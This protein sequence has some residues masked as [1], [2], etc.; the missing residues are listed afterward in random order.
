[1]KKI[2]VLVVVLFISVFAFAQKVYFVYLQNE[3]HEP[4]F[5]RMNNKIYSSSSSGYLILSKLRDSSYNVNIGFPA[6][7]WPEQKFSFTVNKKD[8]GFLLK[9]FNEREWGLFDM[10]TMTVQM[11]AGNSEKDAIKTEKKEVNTFTEMLSKAADDSTLK[12][13]PVLVKTEEKKVEEIKQ[14]EEKKD[15]PKQE[16][17]KED[18]VIEK[19]EEIKPTEKKEEPVVEIKEQPVLN[20]VTKQIDSLELVTE[21]KPENK[22]AEGAYEKSTVKRRSESSTTEGFGLIFVDIYPGGETDTIRILIPNNNRIE[23]IEEIKQE[24]KEVK[25]VDTVQNLES[26]RKSVESNPVL[27]KKNTCKAIAVEDDFFK[28]RKKMAGVSSDDNMIVEARKV[29]RVKCFTTQQ[30]R[31]LSLLFLEDEG[32]YKFFDAAYNYI[33]D[34]ENFASLQSE[35]QGDYFINRFK[36]MLR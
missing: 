14:P 16:L 13:K 19:K 36:A 26:I 4:F 27:F 7:Q 18:I 10:Q 9:N 30:V 34:A 33:S 12:E 35:L 15:E 24:D 1:M 11:A 5:V 29:F 25:P 21:N 2:S 23:T 22:P 3:G 20:P 28:L 6:N 31:N 17:K 32:K 8:Q